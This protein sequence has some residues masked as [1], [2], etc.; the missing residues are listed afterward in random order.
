ME[1]ENEFI[2][3]EEERKMNLKPIL[4]GMLVGCIL[5]SVISGAIYYNK[6]MKPTKEIPETLENFVTEGDE[7]LNL[8]ELQSWIENASE[9]VSKKY[10]YNEVTTYHKDAK[11]VMGLDVP[12]TEETTLILF[13]GTIN[14]GIDVSE[15][16]CDIDEETKRIT[17]TLPEPKIIAH[18]IDH[19]SVESYEVKNAIFSKKTYEEFAEVISNAKKEKENSIK[20]NSEF[21]DEI[22][23]SAQ[24]TLLNLLTAF[25]V[26][27]SYTIVFK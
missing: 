25:G 23:D 7:T 21:F 11:K 18:E 20:E 17:L 2:G 9:L 19:D 5:T 27:E 12:L 8:S 1:Q 22:A 10:Y 16:V 15:I 4:I 26:T 3:F 13:S 14:A 24:N 6:V